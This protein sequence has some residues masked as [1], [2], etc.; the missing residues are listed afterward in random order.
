SPSGNVRRAAV[1]VKARRILLISKAWCAMAVLAGSF[2]VA[3]DTAPQANSLC[4]GS[5]SAVLGQ[6]VLGHALTTASVQGVTCDTQG[7]I[8]PGVTITVLR[9]GVPMKPVASNGE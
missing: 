8:L 5:P 7:R 3:S 6:Q 2:A 4:T 1:R 9:A